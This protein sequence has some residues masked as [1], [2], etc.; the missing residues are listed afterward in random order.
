MVA[1][2]RVSFDRACLKKDFFDIPMA[3]HMKGNLRIIN[4]KAKEFGRSKK[5]FFKDNF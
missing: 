3:T 1:F 4:L 2:L 5:V